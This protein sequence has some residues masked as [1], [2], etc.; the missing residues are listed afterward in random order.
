L[1]PNGL[2]KALTLVLFTVGLVGCSNPPP[3]PG[4]PA[5]GEPT[6]T[7]VPVSNQPSL[8]T[9]ATTP[10]ITLVAKYTPTPRL[11]TPAPSEGT[12]ID[13]S[14]NSPDGEWTAL[15]AFET[16]STGYRVSLTITNKDKSIV[17]TPVDYQ[18]DGLGYSFPKPKRWSA[19]SRY[20]YYLESAV[21]DGC[22]DFY[23]IETNWQR[24]DVQSGQ[25]DKF[26][27]PAGRG[28]MFSPDESTLAYIPETAPTNLVL[29]EV[30]T[31]TETRVAL[32]ITLEDGQIPQAGGILWSPDGDQIILA[33][34]NGNICETKQLEF[35]LITI[36]I[37]DLEV[38]T[39]Y[40]SKD[41]IRPLAW[42]AND[43]MRVMDWNSKSWWIDSTS[44][45]ITTAP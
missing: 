16:L 41:F 5:I 39:L 36:Q 35:Y 3:V 38:E 23:S 9:N 2:F 26:D 33:A 45:E 18:G 24:F 8:P 19:D 14:I 32:P 22:G 11:I 28:H 7:S 27:L 31:Q 29:L 6:N 12:F 13:Q 20:F 34:A 44:G 15:P 30:S 10:Q 40:Q 25:V 1:K 43:K 37:S 42:G 4:P 17:W 21:V